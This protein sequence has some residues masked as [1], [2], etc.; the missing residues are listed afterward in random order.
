MIEAIVDNYAT[1]RHPEGKA[2]LARYPRWTF[3]FTPTSGSWLNAVETFFSALTRQ[4]VG[5]GSFHSIVNLQVAIN[6]YLAERN[7][8][9]R[10]FIWTASA[11]SIL[12]KLARLPASSE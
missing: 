4:R 9:P 3:H 1:H 8:E 2:W 5:R 10:P 12:A 11:A 7:A 6:R